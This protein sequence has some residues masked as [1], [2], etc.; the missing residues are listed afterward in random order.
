[1]AELDDKK[2][3]QIAREYETLRIQ[4]QD[5]ATIAQVLIKKYET[6]KATLNKL[7]EEAREKQPT[8]VKGPPKGE[9][10]PA[11]GDQMGRAP[12]KGTVQSGKEP[13]GG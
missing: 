2:K 3:D 10:N 4:N 7:V 11:Q 5:E 12:P 6:D 1:M 8:A 9:R 13:K